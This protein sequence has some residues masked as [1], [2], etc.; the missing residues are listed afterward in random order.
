LVTWLPLVVLALIE[1]RRTGVVP[2]ILLDASVHARP[3]IA[4]P[5]FLV[6]ERSLN[7]RTRECASWLVTS[8]IVGGADVPRLERLFEQAAR[9]RDSTVVEVLLAVLAL[10]GG[11]VAVWGFGSPLG[12]ITGRTL[13]GSLVGAWL[14]YAC[15]TLPV[16]QFLLF[17][18][19]WRWLIWTR[20]LW[21]ISRLDLHLTATHPDRAG[22]LKLISRP[23]VAFG[24][25]YMAQSVTLAAAWIGQVRLTVHWEEHRFIQIVGAQLVLALLLSFG[26]LLV[27]A[28]RL[29][30]VRYRGQEQYADL[31]GLYTQLFHHR[32][33]EAQ[34]EAGLLGSPDMEPLAA[35]DTT[36][37]TVEHMRIVPI[38]LLGV[39]VVAASVLLP[40]VPLVLTMMPLP[41][42]LQRLGRLLLGSRG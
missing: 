27:F 7:S 10:L 35:L 20:A 32:W 17:R 14:W 31:A 42:L 6:A 38:P 34:A 25:V 26:P 12:L 15:V 4:I 16:F 3:L 23:S 22:G 39:L 18:W 30:L 9:W 19:Y 41:A 21:G 5:L 29:W 33:I 36:C 28:H 2:S 40:M 13:E 24:W 11:P 1:W 8:G 37:E